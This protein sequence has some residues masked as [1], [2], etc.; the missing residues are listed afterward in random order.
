M[1]IRK[2]Q[3][4]LRPKDEDNLSKLCSHIATAG[5][6]SFLE[7]YYWAPGA[8]SSL[9]SIVQAHPENPNIKIQIFEGCHLCQFAYDVAE[10]IADHKN[11]KCSRAHLLNELGNDRALVDLYSAS[12]HSMKA[13]KPR[14]VF[15]KL[16]LVSDTSEFQILLSFFEYCYAKHLPLRVFNSDRNQLD[17]AIGQMR[18]YRAEYRKLIDEGKDI[19]ELVFSEKWNL[20]DRDEAM[21]ELEGII[22]NFR[23]VRGEDKWLNPYN[24]ETIPFIGRESELESLDAFANHEDK[25]KIWAVEAPSGAGKT[26]LAAHWRFNST[27]VKNW[28]CQKLESE[29]RKNPQ[30]WKDWIPQKPT[31]IILDYMF[32]YEELLQTLI[33]R[34]KLYLPYNVRL[35][36]LDHVFEKP[37]SRG[38]RWGFSGSGTS[39]DDNAAQFFKTTPLSLHE[40]SDQKEVI[41]RII[42]GRAKIAI[43]SSEMSD[44][45]EHLQKVR[46][47]WHPLFAAIL[48]DAIKDDKEYQHW[49]RQELI[50]YYLGKERLPWEQDSDSVS[51]QII[52]SLISVS[53]ALRGVK[54][55]LIIKQLYD[56]KTLTTIDLPDTPSSIEAIQKYC[57]K[58]ISNTSLDI[59]APFEPDILGESFFL[60]WLDKL[61]KP[62]IMWDLFFR[63][64]DVGDEETKKRNAIEFIA[65]IRRLTSNL[66]ND[67][68]V[69]NKGYFEAVVEFINPNNFPPNSNIRWAA[70]I[71]SLEVTRLIK[72]SR[73]SETSNA[74]LNNVNSKDICDCSPESFLATTLKG[75]MFCLEYKE[76]NKPRT[77]FSNN[78][79]QFLKKY[80]AQQ[81]STD[82]WTPLILASFLN[83]PKVSKL[84]ARSKRELQHRTVDGFNALAIACQEGHIE[85]VN[86]LIDKGA[87][88]HEV[89]SPEKISVLMLASQNGHLS[90]V[91]SLISAGAAIDFRNDEGNTAFLTSCAHGRLEIMKFLLPKINLNI[92]SNNGDSALILASRFGRLKLV[93]ELIKIGVNIHE[94]NLDGK[95]AY[96]AAC[97]NGHIDVIGLLLSKGAN[98]H[99]PDYK[100]AN[101]LM[102]ASA[103]GHLSTVKL[104]IQLG[105]YVHY[106]SFEGLNALSYA[107]G[108]GH[109]EIVE[110]L[111]S[112]KASIYEKDKSGNTSLTAACAYG[113]LNVAKKLIEHF[114]KDYINEPNYNGQTCLMHAARRGQ[115]KVVKFLVKMGADVITP[116]NDGIT[117]LCWA[118]FGGDIYIIEMLLETEANFEKDPKAFMILCEKGHNNALEYILSNCLDLNIDV[119]NSSGDSAIMYCCEEGHMETLKLLVKN[120]AEINTTS[121]NG[122]RPI[123]YASQNGHLD[124][125]NFLLVSGA[126]IEDDIL[127]L[128][129][130]SQNGHF[131]VV[132]ALCNYTQNLDLPSRDKINTLMIAC[133]NNHIE[134]VQYLI[135]KRATVDA[136]DNKE[137]TALMIASIAGSFDSAKILVAEGADVNAVCLDGKTAA[138]FAQTNNHAD[139]LKL[140]VE[141]GAWR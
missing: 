37:L 116:D 76:E 54:F 36:V 98:I 130:A 14:K 2:Y 18:E 30:F 22:S 23:Q 7:K 94:Q 38:D 10:D 46:C 16:A 97:I 84:L 60:M 24:H 73:F 86:V 27:V 32:G 62:P 90:I 137:R 49:N 132:K 139:I 79:N 65:F 96:I 6:K 4:E 111:M 92:K 77:N 138:I 107:V 63:L 87:D 43:Q 50:K 123:T 35:L 57:N 134:I 121:S 88:V 91:K 110:L 133:Q 80:T 78:E 11:E 51:I 12:K 31:L 66:L 82:R 21:T 141:N 105:T 127:P 75:I 93:W 19:S 58:I 59:L 115:S 34:C 83:F 53:T 70:N 74:L 71:S 33:S 25:F 106:R 44:A 41:T 136:R 104:L 9:N 89:I 45:I 108:A 61:Q 26:R 109:L 5:R 118:C 101:A 67:D 1:E 124:L 39:E 112:E 119:T 95:N 129:V 113:K 8:V 122:Y 131:N 48:A 81:E 55:N 47:A 120:G 15:E 29:D 42:A 13:Q 126:K 135:S 3:V 52:S 99:C 114:P 20:I 69:E 140:L 40:P 102:H 117:P 125:V 56:N 100:G 17:R 68:S 72:K 128:F 64:F 85:T 28:Y 103:E